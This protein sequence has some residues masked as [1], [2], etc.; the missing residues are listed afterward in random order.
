MREVSSNGCLE[1]VR[2]W[3]SPR[4][5]PETDLPG[6]GDGPP[7]TSRHI[8]QLWDQYIVSFGQTFSKA[9]GLLLR[10]SNA[11]SRILGQSNGLSGAAPLLAK[12]A[13]RTAEVATATSVYVHD[14]LIAIV[15]NVQ[16]W[17][18]DCE[19]VVKVDQIVTGKD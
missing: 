15:A 8:P 14:M 19:C 6:H 10:F 18:F 3:R 9:C 4:V 13:A 1:G 16:C 5:L 7:A 12:K 2:G 17:S 11:S